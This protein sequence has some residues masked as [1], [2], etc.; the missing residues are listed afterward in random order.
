MAAALPLPAEAN[1]IPDRTARFFKPSLCKSTK[2]A[3]Y[4]YS[5][6]QLAANTHA[7]LLARGIEKATVLGHSMGG[8][9]AARYA[10]MFPDQV[11]Q[12]VLVNPLG[13]EDWRLKGVPPASVDAAYQ[14]EL[15]TSFDSIK[16]YQ[17]KFYYN[18]EWKP[19]YDRWVEMLAGMYAGDGK[20]LV[21]WNQAL[22]SDMIYTQPV[23]HEFSRIRLK[24]LLLIGSL[25]RT[26]PGGNRA[27]PEVAERLGRYA[28][29]GPEAAQIIPDAELVEFPDLGHSPQV[30]APDR[31]H[32]ALL[33]GLDQH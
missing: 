31:F 26:A 8:M 18:G 15:T 16:A 30:E 13:L 23:I 12:L 17:R 14:N 21:A 5:F 6:E 25:D 10:L 19:E 29:L 20:E 1:H 2:P 9:L 32:Q 33:K 24:T 28:E 7:L 27:S 22:T 4:Q 11:E 3:A